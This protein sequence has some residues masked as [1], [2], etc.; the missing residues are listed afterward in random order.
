MQNWL[1]AGDRGG[2]CRQQRPTHAAARLSGTRV[3]FCYPYFSR[4]A[5]LNFNLPPEGQLPVQLDSGT[6]YEYDIDLLPPA[7]L[8]QPLWKSLL[9]NI[10]H[11]LAPEKFPPLLLTSRPMNIGML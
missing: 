8:T 4:M 11:V 6:H 7:S 10:H 1:S 3:H 9:S 5:A 2:S